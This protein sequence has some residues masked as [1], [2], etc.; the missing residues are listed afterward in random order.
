MIFQW[1]AS[2]GKVLQA[3]LEKFLRGGKVTS[4]Y[5]VYCEGAIFW[6]GFQGGACILLALRKLPPCKMI[7]QHTTVALLKLVNAT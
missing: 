1:F 5:L 3:P 6:P 7:S 2:W 4:L